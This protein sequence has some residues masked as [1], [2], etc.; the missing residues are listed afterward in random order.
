MENSFQHRKTVGVEDFVLLDDYR[1][2]D[3]FL[4]NLKK[5]FQE[6]LIYVRNF[7]FFLLEFCHF[8]FLAHEKIARK[9]ILEQG[10]TTINKVSLDWLIDW[11]SN[12]ASFDRLIDALID[13]LIDALIDWSMLWLIDWSMLWLTGRFFDWLI[14]WLI[15]WKIIQITGKWFFSVKIFRKNQINDQND[16][17]KLDAL[18]FYFFYFSDLYRKRVGNYKCSILL[19]L[20]F[21]FLLFFSSFFSLFCIFVI[22]RAGVRESLQRAAHLRCPAHGTLPWTK[23]LR[24]SA[25]C[26][27]PIV[28]IFSPSWSGRWAVGFTLTY[29]LGS[30]ETAILSIISFNVLIQWLFLVRLTIRFAIA[31]T[32]YRAVIHEHRDECILISGESGSGKTEV[33]LFAGIMSKNKHKVLV[34]GMDVVFLSKT[35]AEWFKGHSPQFRLTFQGCLL[36]FFRSKKNLLFFPHDSHP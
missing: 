13:W 22:F 11:S 4:E 27:S 21:F 32:A 30:A 25:A 12:R 23:F 3:A 7:I 35:M 9:I 29:T 10:E 1:S 28:A 20:S 2:E 34:Q 16:L 5:R 18:I 15:D 6:D 14:D 17:K 26:V 33:G 31:D 36:R 24:T 8:V 19:F